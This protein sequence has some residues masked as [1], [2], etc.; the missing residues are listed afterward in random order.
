M[1]DVGKKIKELRLSKKLTQKAL[2]K[3]LNV[4][5]QAI[6]KWER[7]ESNPDLQTLLNLS[8]YF[9]VSVDDILGNKS[10]NFFDSL[11]SKMKGSKKM[12]KVQSVNSENVSV[13]EEEKKVIIFD[14]VFS[15]ITDEGLLQTQLLN[16]KLELLMK[17]KEKNI[18]IETYN[19][20]KVDLYGEQADII[21][22][23]PTFGYA[24]EEIEKKFPETPVIAISKRD[25]GIL[26]TEK[27][28]TEIMEGLG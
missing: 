5:P 13:G 22:L 25:Y 20:N 15:F 12:K 28:Y 8:H 11:F 18:T 10:Q 23:T 27:L 14:V 2:A 6:S 17:K 1:L 21:L 26:N 4:T 16:R 19:S 9:N 7:N 3:T 24:K